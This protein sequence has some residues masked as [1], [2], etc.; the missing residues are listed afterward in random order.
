MILLNAIGDFEMFPP[1]L[2]AP[3]SPWVPLS[4]YGRCCDL[5]GF[6]KPELESDPKQAPDDEAIEVYGC[7]DHR[8]SARNRKPGSTAFERGDEASN[9]SLG[10]L[11]KPDFSL[12]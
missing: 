7:S 8:G 9:E 3:G 1:A 10:E 5:T 4:G 6:L 11:L 2:E 12:E